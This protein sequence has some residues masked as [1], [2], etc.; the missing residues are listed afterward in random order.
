MRQMSR[1]TEENNSESKTRHGKRIGLQVILKRMF[2]GRKHWNFDRLV[3]IIG[4]EQLFRVVEELY[5]SRHDISNISI[6]NLA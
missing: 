2:F 4:P 6:R 5:G 1:M 3:F